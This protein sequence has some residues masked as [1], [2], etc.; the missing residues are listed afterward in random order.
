M[1]GAKAAMKLAYE[2]GARLVVSRLG[3]LLAERE[4]PAYRLLLEALTDLGKVGV[5]VGASLAIRTGAQSG[6]Q[7]QALLR[8]LPDSSLGVD[9][10]PGAL[11]QHD[12]SPA[13]AIQALAPWVVSVRACDGVRDLSQGRAVPVQ[14]GRGSVDFPDLFSVLER[15]QYGGYIL[16]EGQAP[17]PVRSAAEA[18]EYLKSLF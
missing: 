8:D 1:E 5:R 4:S 11:V 3:P 18:I 14:L 10:D 16:I 12:H 13:D 17:D 2:L 15:Q 6:E 7:L 9:F